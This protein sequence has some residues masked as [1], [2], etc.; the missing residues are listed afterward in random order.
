M[1]ERWYNAM[2]RHWLM[3]LIG[4]ALLVAACGPTPTPPP[5][6]AT[7]VPP[8]PTSR[9]TRTLPATWTP[10]P[11][12]TRA[13]PGAETATAETV[14]PENTARPGSFT[15]PPTWTP[16]VAPTVTRRADDGQP[17]PTRPRPTITPFAGRLTRV[18]PTGQPPTPDSAAIYPAACG[19]LVVKPETFAQTFTNQP[20]MISWQ[21]V[22]G[23]QGYRVWVLNPSGRYT[24]NQ[25]T[26]S[27]EIEIPGEIFTSPGPYG[28]EVM[29][30]IDGDRL[31][32]SITG[33]I[34][35]RFTR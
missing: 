33:V 27:T 11:P 23:A 35:A 26:E 31:C 4:A 1:P 15:L 3:T 5:P 12:P 22:E 28:W 24:F 25:I 13:R 30:L 19:S 21:G 2:S 34:V 9:P 10:G 14:A 29:A 20:A 16:F 17:T 32:P 6:T 7:L 18:A 8:T